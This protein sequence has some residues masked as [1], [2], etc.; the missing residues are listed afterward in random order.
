VFTNGVKF[1]GRNSLAISLFQ[2]AET[3]IASTVL[4]APLL[5]KMN[6]ASELIPAILKESVTR[7]ETFPYPS[8]KIQA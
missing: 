1:D 5:E 6:L 3:K 7:R 8:N 4:D 2:D